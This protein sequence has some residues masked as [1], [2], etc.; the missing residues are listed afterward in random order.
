MNHL[1]FLLNISIIGITIIFSFHPKLKFYKIW[2][3]VFLSIFTTLIFFVLWDIIFTIN[4]IWG[5]N[6]HQLIGITL[7]SLPLEDWL[8]FVCIPYACIFT[9][10][11]IARFIPQL[12][13]HDKT[14]SILTHILVA[15]LL[16]LSFLYKDKLY[17]I[18]NFLMAIVILMLVRHTNS[19]LLNTYYITFLV[20]LL[21]FFVFNGFLTGSYSESEII[22]YNNNENLN[23]RLA[24]V[25][26]E[27]LSYAFTLVLSNLMLTHYFVAKFKNQL[28]E[29]GNQ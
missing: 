15:I 21:P 4:G 16:L 14:T 18:I 27:Y 5:F 28:T 24:T 29:E 13:L 10:Y 7:L 12:E 19:R 9:H 3:P 20:M 22:W 17:T 23:L 26:I 11:A 8:F 1:Y 6:Q 2:K 25:P